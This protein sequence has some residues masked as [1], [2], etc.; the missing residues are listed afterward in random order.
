M[1]ATSSLDGYIML[2][3]LPSCQL[4]R[5]ININ[6]SFKL[7]INAEK[8]SDNIF[9]EFNNNLEIISA[10]N[11]F[12]SSSPLPSII[13]FISSKKMF[14]SYTINGGFIN[15]IKDTK[16]TEKITCYKKFKSINFE[17]F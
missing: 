8:I 14:V 6:I 13:I 10:D 12:L 9:Y 1:F 15:N 3:I 16:N 17:E 5:S 11:I 7:N 2:Y 4:V